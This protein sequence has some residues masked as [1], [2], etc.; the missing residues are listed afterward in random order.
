MYLHIE[1]VL[2]PLYEVEFNELQS[3]VEDL[4]TEMHPEAKGKYTEIL[5]DS[6]TNIKNFISSFGVTIQHFFDQDRRDREKGKSKG[7]TTGDIVEEPVDKGG[8][9]Q[10]KKGSTNK[11]KE[12]VPIGKQEGQ[13]PLPKTEGATSFDKPKEPAVIAKT[14]P[15]GPPAKAGEQASPVVPKET[16]APKSI[17]PAAV[18]SVEPAVEGQPKPPLKLASK[19]HSHFDVA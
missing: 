9:S 8:K 18:L 4:P 10:G 6:L 15:Q 19:S 3:Y 1:D 17:A 11:P 13:T 2:N 5:V 7:T 12:P 16:A 14:K